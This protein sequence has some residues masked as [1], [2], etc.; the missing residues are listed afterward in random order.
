MVSRFAVRGRDFGRVREC[1][2]ASL[3][4]SADLR[5]RSANEMGWQLHETFGWEKRKKREVVG[6][7]HFSIL[8]IPNLSSAVPVRWVQV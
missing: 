4:R 2:Q 7:H 8:F 3:L 1:W 6:V 5:L